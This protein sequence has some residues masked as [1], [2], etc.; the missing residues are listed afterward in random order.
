MFWKT[1]RNT[2]N[3]WLVYAA[4]MTHTCIHVCVLLLPVNFSPLYLYR[5]VD[6][7]D[8]FVLLLPCILRKSLQADILSSHSLPVFRVSYTAEDLYIFSGNHFRISFFISP[9]SIL[10]ISVSLK[11]FDCHWHW[12]MLYNGI[13]CL[14]NSHRPSTQFRVRGA[15]FPPLKPGGASYRRRHLSCTIMTFW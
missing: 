12:H 5:F 8:R 14:F 10:V 11:N 2:L 13:F 3:V 9:I 6:I 1:T 4:H 15:V 7:V